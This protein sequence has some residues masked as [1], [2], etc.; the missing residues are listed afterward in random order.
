MI[1]DITVMY[2]FQFQQQTQ[3]AFMV[4]DAASVEAGE[5]CA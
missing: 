4:A 1:P 2:T 3:R 5:P